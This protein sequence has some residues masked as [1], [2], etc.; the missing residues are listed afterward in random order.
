MALHSADRLAREFHDLYSS[1]DCTRPNGPCMHSVSSI[2]IA[3]RLAGETLASS[4]ALALVLILSSSM[5]LSALARIVAAM[6]EEI[7]IRR[8]SRAIGTLAH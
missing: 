1:P 2:A 6:A 5:R 7:H 3:Y 8:A 4:M